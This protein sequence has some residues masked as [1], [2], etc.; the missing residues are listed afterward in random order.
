MTFTAESIGSALT[1]IARLLARAR[2]VLFITGAGISVDSGLPTY[3]GVTGLYDSGE[4]EDGIRIEEALSGYVLACWPEVSW[5]YI[6]EIMRHCRNAQ[7]NPGHLAISELESMIPE[8]VVL[9]QNVDG[10]HRKAGSNNVIE[11]HGSTVRRDLL[12]AGGSVRGVTGHYR[13]HEASRLG[14]LTGY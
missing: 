14:G 1:E 7:P 11:L 5:K 9:T 4:T 12:P 8:I 6:A 3:R 10:L 2:R 13:A